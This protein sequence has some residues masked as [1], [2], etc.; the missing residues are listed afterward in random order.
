MK[1]SNIDS[2]MLRL[3][4]DKAFSSYERG[5]EIL[6]RENNQNLIGILKRGILK[7]CFYNEKKDTDVVLYHLY[8]EGIKLLINTLY[9]KTTAYEYRYIALENSE[10]LW[11]PIE[12]Y[13]HKAIENTYLIN[14]KLDSYNYHHKQLVKKTK[15]AVYIKDNKEI[16]YKYLKFKMYITKN[17]SIDISIKEL[18]SDLN[19]SLPIVGKLIKELSNEEKIKRIG[20]RIVITQS[21]NAFCKL[22]SNQ[23]FEE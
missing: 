9:F 22:L 10:I 4:K 7:I 8:P 3:F 16:L 19:L 2:E 6:I 23:N 20:R 15:E 21:N 5:E 12:E 1:V 13:E 18:A 14:L 17:N 11:L